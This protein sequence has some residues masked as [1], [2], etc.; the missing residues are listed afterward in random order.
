MS[1]RRE[2]DNRL[3]FT[4]VW[5]ML[6]SVIILS[7]WEPVTRAVASGIGK[8]SIGTVQDEGGAL[9]QEP[10]INFI[11]AGVTCVDDAGNTRSNCTIPGGGGTNYQTMQ[12]EGGALTQ[13]AVMDFAGAGVTCVDSGGSKSLCTIPGGGATQY[14]TM[15]DEG[16][17]L[18]QRAI[19]DF[20]GAGVTC[21]DSGGTKSLCTIPGGG[22]ATLDVARMTRAAVQTIA[23]AGVAVKILFDT[24]D[25]DVGASITADAVTNNRFDINTN[26]K[27]LV[28]GSWRAENVTSGQWLGS[29]IYVN[30]ASVRIGQQASSSST[31]DPYAEV[32][33]ILDLTAG[34]RV[35]LYVAHSSVGTRNTI[36]SVDSY[37]YMHIILIN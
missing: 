12:D 27:Y 20:A 34:D 33:K 15:Q 23:T 13:R 8:A 9:A 14:Q 21:V 17:A 18:T 22:A 5:C 29:F 4:C 16:G 6:A 24:V 3:V 7:L 11:G 35:E 28:T 30:G 10:A 2:S 19:M 31:Q 37:P 26:G 25:F 32:T 36:A 1:R